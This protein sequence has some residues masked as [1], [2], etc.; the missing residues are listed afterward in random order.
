[1]ETEARKVKIEAMKLKDLK[2][3]NYLFQAIDHTILERI[4]CKDT[5]KHIWD[6]MR[7]KYQSCAK[8]KRQQLQDL[9]TEFE[10][11]KMK[12]GKSITY[13]FSRVMPIVNKVRLHGD[14]SDDVSIVEKILRSV[15]PKFNFVVFAIEE[16][17]DIDNLSLD[18]LQSS[19][20]VNEKKLIQPEQEEKSLQVSTP[21]GKHDKTETNGYK[22]SQENTNG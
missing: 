22:D 18:E 6:S 2:A 4:L 12:S 20:L 5:S 16:S 17:H 8:T 19:L 9:R 13:Y 15:T 11:L 10:T 21:A 3:K 7:R 14:K 1:M